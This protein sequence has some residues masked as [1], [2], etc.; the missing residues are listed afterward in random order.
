MH[1][2]FLTTQISNDDLQ[3]A[4]RIL[5]GYCGMSPVHILRRHLKWEGPRTRTPKGIDPAFIQKQHR[6]K[7]PQWKALSE[8]LGRQSYVLTL[9]YDVDRGQFGQTSTQ[10]EET[11]GASQ[12]S[13][14]DQ[15]P[16]ILRWSDLPDPAG[17]RPVN[18]RLIVNIEN[19]MGLCT[20][21]KSMNHRFS[22][23]IIQECN[24][25]VHGNV[26]FEINRYLQLPENDTPSSIRTEL[27]PY[28]SLVPFDGD[29]KWILTASVL[30]LDGNN[31]EQMQKGIDELAA[32][33][34]D[35]EGCFN[36]EKRDRHIFDTRI[37]F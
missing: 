13:G 10:S 1:E 36:L 20:V 17:N 12:I 8:Q 18:S 31:P 37:K 29:N 35:F 19:E 6:D 23:E 27:P 11:N 34:L 22:N 3:R 5:Q 16:G 4:L 26:I 14:C 25:F 7:V 21:L 30:V 15:I 2:L 9:I 33:M 24:R 28:E 32:V